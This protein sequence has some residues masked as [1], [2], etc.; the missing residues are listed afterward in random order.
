MENAAPPAPIT[1]SDSPVNTVESFH[2]LGSIISQDLKREL[3]IN[4]L[5]KK[6]QQRMYFLWQLK[7]FNLLKA[8]MVHF[9]TTIIESIITSSITIWY[10]AATAQDK[11]RDCKQ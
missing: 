1:L 10:A 2:F 11:G 8:M 3:N 5:R 4:S 7:K 6:T 9:Y